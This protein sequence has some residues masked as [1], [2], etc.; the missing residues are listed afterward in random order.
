MLITLHA[1]CALSLP[2]HHNEHDDV[3]NHKSRNCLL[4]RLFRH[5]SKQT[6]K[7][8]VTGLCAGNSPG[9]CEFP[10]QMASNAANV[11]I[12]WRHH[13]VLGSHMIT[14]CIDLTHSGWVTHI[15]VRKVTIIVSDNG[16]SPPWR[17]AIIWTNGGI[18]LAGPLGI[19]FNEISIN[20]HTFSFQKIHLEMLSGKWWPFCPYLNVL[21]KPMN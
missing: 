20:I 14:D 1:Y 17:W 9:T 19:N 12:W 13:V 5:R 6:S 10:A 3:P 11:S 4:N 18:L 2:W 7:L 16:L 8:R 15:C 21:K